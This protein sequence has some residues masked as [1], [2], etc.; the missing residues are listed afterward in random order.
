MLTAS[1]CSGGDCCEPED[2]TAEVW[3]TIGNG[4]VRMEQQ[5]DRFFGPAPETASA[6]IVTV[7]PATTYQTMEGFGAAMTNSSAYLIHNHPQ[8][9]AILETLFSPTDGIGISYVRIPLGA[10][11][12]TAE[13]ARGYTYND[14]PAG[15]TDPDLSE[16]SIA[17]AEAFILPVLRDA[18]ALNPALQIMATPWSA[19][20]WMKANGQLNGG[21][22]RDDAL[23]AFARYL[24]GTLEAYEAAGVPIAALTPQNE[25]LHEAS[26]Y[27]TMG[28]SAA[29]QATFIA[30]HLG[31]QLQASSVEANIIAYDHNWD[32][33]DYPLAVLNN[34]AANAYVDGVA[35]HCYAGDVR[36]QSQVHNAHPDKGTYFTECS[37]GAWSTD[38]GN[39]LSW[40]MRN[41][42]IG[43]TRNWAKTVLLWNLALDT[44]SG[45]FIG[46]CTNC[47]GVLTVSDAGFTREVEYETIGHFSNFVSPG[48]IRIAS[49]STDQLL[50]TAFLNTDGTVV[51][52]AHNPGST[53]IAFDIK[54]QNEVA[55][56]NLPAGSVATLR[57]NR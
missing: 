17:P 42:F 25:P 48:A 18:L 44:Q 14:L 37:G 46:G 5:A 2:R 33:P 35:W 6:L 3:L 27:P 21:E 50:T 56:Y 41:L 52:V 24:V 55:A 43:G 19:P 8:R 28:M 38:Y 36:A 49:T 45:P 7:D 22:L 53:G 4:S 39:N 13:P 23:D 20:A 10:S 11:D 40:N 26:N 57:W 54:Y 34:A 16:L 30:E 1:A 51:L 31:P 32:R 29:Q 9:Q 12:F 47:R 15:A